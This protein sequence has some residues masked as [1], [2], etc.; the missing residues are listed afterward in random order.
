MLLLPPSEVF[1]AEQPT[2]YNDPGI[3]T[4]F[5]NTIEYSFFILG[6]TIIYL[7][8]SKNKVEKSLVF[9]CSLVA[10]ILSFSIASIL[11]LLLAIFIFL[12]R[13]YK[14]MFLLATSILIL[15]VVFSN[16]AFFKILLGMD[17]ETWIQ[18]S[19]DYNRIGY[20]T[21]LMPEFLNGNLKDI[22]L[23]FGY[24]G[25]IVGKKL[26]HYA[27]APRTLID[28]SN[29]LKYLKDV[30]WI[31]IILS[32]GV[33]VFF[34]TS[35]ILYIIYKQAKKSIS[36][37]YFFIVK[38][39]LA[40]IIFIGLFNQIMDVKGFTF[41]FWIEVAIVLNSPRFVLLN[42]KLLPV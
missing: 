28:N 40:Q 24:D 5:I 1:G 4:T 12:D 41:C 10:T 8:Q 9:A 14:I 16:V 42:K 34:I 22:F 20:F 6:L 21:K 32:Q 2:I 7:V 36:K 19:S 35:W 26:A 38:I 13:K 30:Y 33:I 17:I 27:S 15:V 39:F 29:N 18:I 23:G 31:S 25:G 11:G 3:T 37:E